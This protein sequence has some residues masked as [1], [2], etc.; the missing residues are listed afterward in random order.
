VE[1]PDWPAEA[2]ATTLRVLLTGR[3]LAGARVD[4]PFPTGRVTISASGTHLFLDLQLPP[5]ASPGTYSLRV[6][7]GEGVA[8]A[9]FAIVAP[10]PAAGRFQGF[11]PDDVIYL[12]MPDR[13]A[14]GDPRNDDPLVS[15]GMYDRGKP[16]Y[17]HGGD[18]RGIIEHLP[19]LKDLGVTAIWLTPIYD[20][21]NHLNQRERYDNEGITDYHGYGAVDFYGVEEHFGTFDEFRE[22]VDRAHWLGIKVIQD[23]VAN[24]TGPYHPWIQDPPTPAWFHGSEAAP[25]EHLAHLDADRSARFA[26]RAGKHSR[27]LVRR[28]SAGSEP[29][30]SRGCPLPHSEFTV[31]DWPDRN[32]RRPAGHR[33]V[34][35]AAVL[36]RLDR[37]DPCT[38]SGVQNLGR[39]VRRRPGAALVLSGRNDEI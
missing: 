3:N 37:R 7:N 33:A 29:G 10:L 16:R 22:L 13:F 21:V 32:R 18:F 14:N 24:H 4:A 26:R 2:Q 28:H 39:G 35:A 27:W 9:R 36:A 20:N 38:I 25:F 12:L 34:C 6:D 19:Y 1:P 5:H 31:V 11:S 8:T 23:Q 30:R 17:Y 15:H